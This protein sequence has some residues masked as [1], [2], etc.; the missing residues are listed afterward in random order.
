MCD[1]SAG[2]ADRVRPDGYK[3]VKRDGLWFHPA[4]DLLPLDSTLPLSSLS[5]SLRG[6][7]SLSRLPSGGVKPFF[8]SLPPL[9]WGVSLSLCGVDLRNLQPNRGEVATA[10]LRHRIILEDVSAARTVCTRALHS[11]SVK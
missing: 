3:K 10:I 7:F 6:G 9:P 1:G 8:L 11:R 5:L 4:S 2:A